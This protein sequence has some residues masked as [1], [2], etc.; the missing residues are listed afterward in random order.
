MNTYTSALELI[1]FSNVIGNAIVHSEHA[2]NQLQLR[3]DNYDFDTIWE[4][5]LGIQ[6]WDL[7][8]QQQ[9]AAKIVCAELFRELCHANEKAPLFDDDFFDDF[10]ADDRQ[11]DFDF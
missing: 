5:I 6:F 4:E 9:K 7:D 11:Q 1:N 2:I 3:S 10:I 8:A